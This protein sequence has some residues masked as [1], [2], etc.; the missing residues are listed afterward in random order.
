MRRA[1]GS[2]AF[3]KLTPEPEIGVTEAIALRAWADNVHVVPLIDSDSE[4]GSLLLGAVEPGNP[5]E[6]LPIEDVA[7]LLRRLRPTTIPENGLPALRQRIDF[8]FDLTV[9]RWRDSP[10]EKH[11]DRDLLDRCR[12]AAL[13]LSA[14]G[15]AG[16]VHGDLHP[17]NVLISGSHGLVVIDPRPSIGDPA[18]DAIDWVLA[19]VAELRELEENIAHLAALL[20]DLTPDRLMDWCRATAAMIAIPRLNRG[21]FDRKTRFLLRLAE[22]SA[23]SK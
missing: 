9:G 11:L 10:A 20:P 2:P 19:Q 7:M 21:L 15:P 8:L 12:A 13:A 18:F 6:R 23:V 17:G 5:V 3:L 16:L 14:D 4:S 22:D 1:D